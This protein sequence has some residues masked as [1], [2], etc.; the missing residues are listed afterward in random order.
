[1][2]S[3]V[4]N[5]HSPVVTLVCQRQRR[6][7]TEMRS[8]RRSRAVKSQTAAGSGR[9]VPVHRASLEDAVTQNQRALALARTR[10]SQG[11][12]DFLQVLTA[13]RGL[14]AADQDLADSTTAVSTNLVQLY[15]ALGG[16]WNN[17]EPLGVKQAVR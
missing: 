10:Y 6:L 9:G 5:E 7:R 11:V 15:K 4:S 3:K 14:L 1:M 13:Q 2:G 16:G 8:L 17:A 12:A